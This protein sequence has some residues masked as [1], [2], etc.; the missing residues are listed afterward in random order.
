M[1]METGKTKLL[2]QM[3]ADGV[4][5]IFGNP[6][7]VEQG[8][9]DE[10][11]QYP[12]IQYVT[13]LHESV[14]VGMA[15]GYARAK[16]VPA[17]IQLHS[18][19]GLGN[20]IGMLYQAYRG[21]SPLIVVA[22]EAGIRYDAMDAQMACDLVKMAEPVT[23]YAARVTHPSSL[24]RLW[25]RAYKMAMTP[26]MGP[27]FLSI[28]LDILDMENEE[29][30]GAA[31]LID[32]QAIPVRESVVQVA[33]ALAEAKNPMILAGDG[34][35]ESGG[36][37]EL[38]RCAQLGAIPVYGVN[39]SCINISQSSAYYQGD[40]G[41]MF[42]ENSKKVVQNADVV[43]ILGTYAFPEVFPE[44]NS[45]FRSDAKVFHI[46][47]N[48]YEIA[49]NHPVTMGIC[50]S[51]KVALAQINEQLEGEVFSYKEQRETTLLQAKGKETEDATVIGEF[52][53]KLQQ[54][55]DENVVIFDEALT[56]AQYL[57]TYLPRTLEGTFF[58]TRGGSL[59][60]G[61]PGGLGIRLA[62]PKKQV[63]VF[64]G[65]G[66][67]MYTI[68]ALHTASRYHIPIKIVILNNKRYHLLDNNLEVYRKEHQIPEHQ[69]PDC[70]SLEPVIDF[71]TLARSMGVDGVKVETRAQ[72][73]DAA[74][75]L[76]RADKPFL[77]DLNCE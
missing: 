50:A 6:G 1:N 62:C 45:P 9:L 16:G 13:C 54:M 8:I 12:E 64:T 41:H 69:L 7:T 55:T 75:M 56:S 17:V 59:G 25:R 5:H 32:F 53:K 39:N 77:V 70:F 74:E 24:L 14:A 18:G 52:M 28:P 58:Q 38:E 49:K 51:P 42:G 34:V 65:D 68:Q 21:H 76:M 22:G 4:T 43:L 19:V 47:L 71:V 10:L 11:Y 57:A 31:S 63:V 40:L 20:G 36:V 3:I 46:D 15:D 26:P 73:A 2:R 61:I 30:I 67:S 44:L 35:S 23:K 33:R 72:A 60:V 37:A 48:V 66:G 29:E 27:V